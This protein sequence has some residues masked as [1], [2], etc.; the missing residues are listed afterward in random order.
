MHN[1][2]QQYTHVNKETDVAGA[3]PHRL[4]QL[5]FEGGLQRI[6]EARGHLQRG[7]S[8]RLG[9]SLGK[10]LGI[11]SGLQ[12]SL[13]REAGGEIAANLHDLY[14]YMARRL[15]K[16]HV[17]KTD[18]ALVEVSGLLMEIKTAWEGIRPESTLTA[19]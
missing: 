15:L 14:D 3:D 13:N 16:V 7:D 5:L 17:D 10:A 9:E 1:A 8:A 4:I 12:A 18:A 11:I 2:M 6:A 19:G